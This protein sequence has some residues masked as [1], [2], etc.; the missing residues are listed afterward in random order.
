MC[1][2]LEK[3]NNGQIDCL[4]GID[5]PKLCRTKDHFSSIGNFY[6]RNDA[7]LPCKP[8]GD[9]CALGNICQLGIDT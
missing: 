8:V 4:G 7:D 5:E 9:V 2:S 1:L 6:S 3:A